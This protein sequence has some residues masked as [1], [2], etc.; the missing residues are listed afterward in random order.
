M[1][2][3]IRICLAIGTLQILLIGSQLR[4]VAACTIMTLVVGD[5]VWMGNNEDFT[6]RGAVWFVPSVEGKFG[7][8]NFGFHDW[9][10]KRE[11]F[12]QGSMNEKGLAFDAAVTPKVQWAADDRKPSP[13]NL[14]ELIMD[15]CETVNEAVQMFRDNNCH[16]LSGGQFLFADATGASAVIAW[17]SSTGLSVEHRSGNHQVVANTH[18]ADTTYRCARWTRATQVISEDPQPSFDTV[19]RALEAVH[20]H[21]KGFTSYSCIYDLKLR[22]VS[23]YNLTNFDEVVTFDLSDELANGPSSH[24]LKNLFD[25]SP[26]LRE[27]TSKQQRVDFGTRIK[28]GSRD[29]NRLAGVYETETNPQV[30]VRV[31]PMEDG[32]RVIN[33]GQSDAILFPESETVFRISPDRGQVSF[34][35]NEQNDVISLTLHKQI[36]VVAKRVGNR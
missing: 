7:R 18:L 36:D 4:P 17:N 34:Q 23:I 3:S 5:Q 21:G 8:V 26:R 25:D 1:M 14:I 30:T 13:E 31:E 33:E 15:T 32:L 19:R 9:V 6:K 27:V 29:L 20:Q 12:A 35:M 24:L 28:I 22:R 11:N 10:G 16:H 2:K